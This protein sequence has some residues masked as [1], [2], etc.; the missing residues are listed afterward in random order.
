M[1]R[2]AILRLFAGSVASLSGAGFALA[3]GQGCSSSQPP[4]EAPKPCDKQFV[5][6]DIYASG[7]LNPNENGNPRPVVVRLYQLASELKLQNARYDDVLNK[8]EETLGK[9][10]LKV[11]EV[12][13]FPN[14]HFQVKFERM[15][16]ASFL[17]GVAL[18]HEPR[19]QS[20][21]TFYEFPL[22]PGEAQCGGRAADGGGLADPHTAFFLDQSKIDNGSQFD[23]SMFPNARPVKK[24]TL[25][26]RGSGEGAASEG[27]AVQ[28][29]K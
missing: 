7:N 27:P 25:S 9:D 15:K 24:L 29:A 6:L 28:G 3:V 8:A 12:T 1:R 20:W 21:K 16:E 23:E 22:A 13:I 19:G 18:V 11:D 2:R 14:D 5:T 17:A 10:V 26:K 4:P